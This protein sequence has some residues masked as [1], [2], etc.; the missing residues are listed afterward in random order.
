MYDTTTFRGRMF[1]EALEA[2]NVGATED[3]GMPGEIEPLGDDMDAAAPQPANVTTIDVD[4]TGFGTDNS[5]VQNEYNPREVER[6]NI[7]IASENSAIGEYFT[8][9][10]ETNVDVLRRLYSDIGEEERFHSEQLI[11]AKSQLTGEKYVPRDPDVKEE[12]EKLLAMGVD[13]ETAMTT[14]VDKVGLVNRDRTVSP[15]EDDQMREDLVADMEVLEYTLYQEALLFQ[16]MTSPSIKTIYERDAAT[17]SFCEAYLENVEAMQSVF[18]EAVVDTSSLP[19]SQQKVIPSLIGGIIQLIRK[20]IGAIKSAGQKFTQFWVGM[21]EKRKSIQAWLKNHS[22]KDIFAKGY[23]LYLWDDNTKDFDFDDPAAFIYL[24]YSITLK[25]ANQY[26]INVPRE[27]NFKFNLPTNKFINVSSVEEGLKIAENTQ[28]VKTK[29]IVDDNNS[30]TIGRKIFGE[31][32][33]KVGASASSNGKSMNV[34][35][36]LAALS[37]D[38]SGLLNIANTVVQELNK[39]Q[40]QQGGAVQSNPQQ[41]NAVINDMKKVTNLYAKW[42]N[43]I[44]HDMQTLMKINNDVVTA[45]RNTTENNDTQAS[46]NRWGA[47]YNA[48]AHDKQALEAKKAALLADQ[49]KAPNNPEIANRIKAIDALLEDPEAYNKFAAQQGGGQ[50]QTGAPAN[51]NQPVSTPA[52]DQGQPEAGA[53]TGTADQGGDSQADDA[54]TDN[55]IPSAPQDLTKLTQ[56]DATKI[57]QMV[58]SGDPSELIKWYYQLL[59]KMNGR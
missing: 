41:F 57:G 28:F 36:E 59:D 10:K 53:A 11:F 14:A 47:E 19:S 33:D 40:G 43:I 30:E 6:L 21:R 58:Q 18:I 5:D 16:I 8:A 54:N 45:I 17:A 52:N 44:N 13:E 25:I 35:N 20:C 39:L 2:E 9:S 49:K 37:S 12:Y 55:G 38:A 31:T 51:P 4:L 50:S 32:T 42:I 1:L 24:L 29:L 3:L 48:I 46:I 26:N 22:L 34:Y 7:L 27:Y 15:E 56:E 23:Y